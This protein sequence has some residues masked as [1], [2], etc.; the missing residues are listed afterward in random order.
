MNRYASDNRLENNS[1]EVVPSRASQAAGDR[2]DCL[3]PCPD[4][5]I[6]FR[7]PEPGQ[8]ASK[9]PPLWRGVAT[10]FSKLVITACRGPLM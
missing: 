7:Q 4:D 9:R 10:R 2:C 8:T 3:A 6:T 5:A 1:R